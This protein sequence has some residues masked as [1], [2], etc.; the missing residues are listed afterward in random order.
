MAEAYVDQGAYASN[1]GATPTWGVPQEGDGSATTAAANASVGSILF[2]AVPTTG[3]FTICG[4]SPSVTG[5][6]SAASVDAAANAL[7]SNIN[8]TTTTVAAAVAYGTPQLRNL[9]YAR[10]PSGGAPAGTCEIMMRVGSTTLNHASNSNV[11]MSHTFDGTAPTITQF[12]GGTGGCWG[13]AWSTAAL[14]V[15]GSIAAVG[16]GLMLTN[17]MV[18][19]SG[20]AWGSTDKVVIRTGRNLTLSS[21]VPGTAGTRTPSYLNYVFDDGTT[22]VGDSP[23]SKL[24][25]SMAAGGGGLWYIATGSRFLT[26]T[27]RQLGGLTFNLATAG[28]GSFSIGY[29]SNG[30]YWGLAFRKVAFVETGT[31][32]SLLRVGLSMPGYSSR[33]SIALI[34]CLWDMSSSVRTNLLA[35]VCGIVSSNAANASYTFIGNDIR[36][37]LSG[38]G[39]TALTYPWLTNTSSTQSLDV[40]FR[41]NKVSIGQPQLLNVFSTTVVPAAGS[42]VLIENN[43]GAGMPFGSVGLMSTSAIG[44]TAYLA[45]D[46]LDVGGGVK[47][48]TRKGYA[49]WAPGM[50]YMSAQAADG[51]YWSWVIYWTNQTAIIHYGLP[52]STPAMRIQSR[53]ATAARSWTLELLCDA[54]AITNLPN[55]AFVE[56]EYVNASG[57]SVCDVVTAA[58]SASSASWGNVSNAP[59]NAWTPKKI[60]GTTSDQVK[61]N[62]V[63]NFRIV[64][65]EPS[66]AGAS[67]YAIDPEVGLT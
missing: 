59:Y 8:A 58:L 31:S 44:D 22:W 65:F 13:W 62:S 51:T 6:L 19:Y 32:G 56:I 16:Y 66:E 52:Y 2:N 54:T 1:L 26:Y 38:V 24:T 60:T 4:V 57:D 29:D 67:T 36:F 34:E 41:G 21:A 49:E 50:P 9:V 35:A 33:F 14:G 17:P 45:Y 61:L 23:S 47:Y 63:M 5:V 30:N 20:F 12:I 11:A 39:G 10:G 43:R 28:S 64:A 3:A 37:N 48:E 7:A 53:L 25:I 27:A 18:V 46:H 42:R 15:S 40:I 55:K